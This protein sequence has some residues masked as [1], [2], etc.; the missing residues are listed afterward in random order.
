MAIVSEQTV[1]LVEGIAAEAERVE[2]PCGDGTMAWRLWG[3]GPPLVLLHGF[4]GSG[5]S[6]SAVSRELAKLHRVITIDLRQFG[7]PDAPARVPS[8][9][10]SRRGADDPSFEPGR[11]ARR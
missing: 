8:H 9:G 6:W 7:R 10:V 5:A 2:T 1:A 11:L 3:S 4:T